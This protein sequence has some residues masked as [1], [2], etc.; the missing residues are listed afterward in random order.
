MVKNLKKSLI[1]G[2]LI[3]GFSTVEASDFYENFSDSTLRMDY[4]FAGG[5]DGAR[6]YVDSS[7]KQAGWAGRKSRLKETPAKGNGTIMIIQLESGDTLYMNSFSTLFQEWMVT[8]EST[9]TPSSFENS[10]LLPLPKDNVDILVELRD[11]RQEKMASLRHKYRKDDELVA[12]VGQKPLPH[13]FLHEGNGENVIDVAIVGEGFTVEEMGKFLEK[14][15]VFTDEI[16]SYEPFA[17]NKDK[18]RFVAVE[19]PSSESGVS[20]PLKNE[21]KNTRFDSHFS[22]FHSARYLTVPRVKRL[23]QSLEGIPYEHILVVVNTPQ[24]GG[25]GIFNS[26]Q[27]A[28][29]DNELTLPVTVHEFGHSFAG[30]ADEYFY[31]GDE[32]ESYPLDIEPWEKNITTLVNFDA[33]WKDKVSSHTPVPTPWDKDSDK[34]SG[35]G[36]YEGGGYK[37]TG[38]YRPTVTCRMRDNF[39]PTF[40]PVCEETLQEIIDFYTLD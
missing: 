34:E 37:T 18:F 39:Y 31:A 5:P 35:I 15:R 30:L 26:Y 21:W 11:N 4:I 10:F 6:I 14:A 16:L 17:S 19:T 13:Q 27:V 33:K 36:V 28:S 25:G 22:T 29:S 3:G 40:C 32:D 12:V 2:I 8:P 7:S 24:Y 9:E 20:I 23:H 38:I 1:I